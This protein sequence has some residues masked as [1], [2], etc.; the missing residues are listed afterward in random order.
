M[1]VLGIET[2]GEIGSVAVCDG[3]TVIAER[4]FKRG[5]RHGKELIPAIKDILDGAGIKLNGIDLLAVDV[6]P[7]SYTGLRVGITCAK[8]V[9]YA[10]NKPV[11]DVVSL[12]VI[13]QN[14][15]DDYDHICPVI[16][17]RREMVYA[18]IYGRV[19]SES[20]FLFEN[21]IST[22]DENALNGSSRFVVNF[23]ER[24]SELLL[25]T[26][27]TLLERIPQGTLLFG[28]G[29]AR[30]ENVF[31]GK[32]VFCGDDIMWIP[33]AFAVAVLGRLRYENGKRCRME[34]LAPVYMRRPEPVENAESGNR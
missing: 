6:G 5:M 25:V 3:S 22:P 28:D 23:R 17:A 32:S 31:Q 9:A 26:P 11:I 33:R 7:G 29:T 4:S 12:D 2:S 13:A 20:S 14:M 30:Y 1:K 19:L 24:E 18:C 10:L 16:D 8:T 34:K 21:N 27:D 15:P